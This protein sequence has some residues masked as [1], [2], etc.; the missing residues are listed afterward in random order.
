MVAGEDEGVLGG[1][2]IEICCGEIN[3]LGLQLQ[4]ISYQY[5][6]RLGTY[7]RFAALLVLRQLG[8]N[9]GDHSV[10]TFKEVDLPSNWRQ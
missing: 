7:F 10:D 2:K 3:L 8:S 6:L 1:W 4:K 5:P 9:V